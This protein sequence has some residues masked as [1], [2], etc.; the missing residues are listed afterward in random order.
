MGGEYDAS[1]P[2][3]TIP[4]QRNLSKFQ[5]DIIRFQLDLD[6]ELLIEIVKLAIKINIE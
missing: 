4:F 3:K 6:N 5:L 2:L 1:P